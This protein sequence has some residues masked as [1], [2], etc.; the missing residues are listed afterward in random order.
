MIFPPVGV[1]D[2]NQRIPGEALV[3][4]QKIQEREPRTVDVLFRERAELGEGKNNIVAVDQKEVLPRR[5]GFERA[6]SALFCRLA[7]L[8]SLLFRALLVALPVLIKGA[9]QDCIDFFQRER[10]ALF[11]CADKRVFAD[12]FRS[13]VHVAPVGKVHVAGGLRMG[14]RL[15]APVAAENRVRRK[16]EICRGIVAPRG[17]DALRIPAGEKARKG[18]GE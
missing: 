12:L 2:R 11:F 13:C 7:R 17:N 18:E 15:A 8:P 3:V 10:G 5:G 14:N 6:V 1:K 9:V 4:G 16:S